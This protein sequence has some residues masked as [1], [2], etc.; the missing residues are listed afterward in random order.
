MSINSSS[1]VE[2]VVKV[3]SSNFPGDFYSDII[4]CNLAKINK[5]SAKNL[6]EVSL[7]SADGLYWTSAELNEWNLG[8]TVRQLV[9]RPTGMQPEHGEA[10]QQR[11]HN[12]I[13]STHADRQG[14]DISFTVFLFVCFFSGEDNSGGVKLYTE[15]HWCPRQKI[16]YFGGLC[17]PRRPKSDESKCT[18]ATSHDE[19]Q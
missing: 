3:V 6:P 2:N 19:S 5:L 8:A 10:D 13:L 11:W 14:V 4:F 15:V 17:S 7:S 9:G 16:S 1:Q 18:L 12:S